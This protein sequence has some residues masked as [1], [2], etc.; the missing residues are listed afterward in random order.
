MKKLLIFALAA[1]GMVA[2]VKEEVTLVPEGSAISFENAFISN[3]TRGAVDPST[4]SNTLTGFNVW[5]FV[6]EYD[7]TIFTKKEVK[8]VDGVWGYDGT[9]FWVPNQPYYF[10]ALA[11]MN[12]ANWDVEL[13]KDEAAK[14]GLGTV[15][16]ENIDGTEDLLY[17]KKKVD[18]KGLNEE[19]ESV[20]FQFQHL[21]SKVKFTFKNGFPTE[22]A[23]I[24]V[25]DVKMEVPASA[26]IDLAQADYSK[27]WSNYSGTTVLEFGNVEKLSYTK[28]AEVANERLTIPTPAS[29]EYIITFHVELFMGA[30]SVYEVDMTSKVTGHELAMGNAYNFT[31]EINNE[32]L[33]LQEIVF[34][35]QVVD[36]WVDPYQD[37]DVAL[38]ELKA[39]A[40]NGGSYTLCEDVDVTEPIYVSGD[41]T[42]DLNGHKLYN[43][44]D[45]W[46]ANDFA[47]LSVEGNGAKLTINGNGTVEAKENDC[48]AIYVANGGEITINGGTYI[49]NIHAVYVSNNG[50]VANLNGGYYDIKQKYNATAP[51]RML[52]N[53]GDTG[54]KNGISKIIVKGGEYVGFDPANNDAEGAN[55]NF[56]AAGYKSEANGSNYVVVRE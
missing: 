23:S 1:M 47:L 10:A 36:S 5:G 21:L 25:S 15:K 26:E 49:G 52:L 30:L 45:L 20:K 32:S 12:S 54:Y 35:I 42:L 39:A 27:A 41:L 29:Q 6:K 11:P 48:Y 22:T 2:C 4:N 53:C 3:S 18:S 50:G 37:V 28:A 9:Q 55:T 43:S 56:V 19:M 40:K 38:A 46:S 7:G 31:A 17:A 13:A 33:Q 51:Y 8:K 34:D 24:I 16:F 44:T 14:L